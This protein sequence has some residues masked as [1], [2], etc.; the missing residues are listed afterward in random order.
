VPSA[1][2]AA[3]SP[4]DDALEPQATQ[5]TAIGAS[6]RLPRGASA[7]RLLAEEFPA[8]QVLSPAGGPE[9]RLRIEQV[10]A[11]DPNT[12]CAGQI[13]AGLE[14]L[15]LGGMQVKVLS[16]RAGTVSG[17]ESRSAWATVTGPGGSRIAGLLVVRT[18][19]GV[20]ASIAT[21]MPT[22][23]FAE[24][25]ALLERSLATL[26]VVD[27][28]AIQVER[29]AAIERGQAFLKSLSKERLRAL[30]DGTSR[31]RRLWRTDEDGEPEELGW[32]EVLLR[33]APRSSAGR[34]GP[35]VLDRPSEREEGLLISMIARTTA[36]DGTD[37]VETRAN[38]WI[39]WDLGSEAW[40]VRS[41]QK[42]SGPKSRFEQ[43]GMLP[44]A[45]GPQ[46]P[47]LMVATDVG[48]GMAEPA[49]WRRPPVAY[50]PQGLALV[51][52]SLLPQNETA[53]SN[54]VFYAL[55]PATGRLCQRLVRWSR[56][57][58]TQ[59]TWK[60]EVQNTPDTPASAEWFDPQGRLVK[61]QEADGS[62]M[63]PSTP[64]EIQR[65]WK[66]LGLDP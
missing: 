39:A 9:W 43:V 59:G 10:W 13:R 45:D 51:L 4:A 46:D 30:A 12:D 47:V 16:E 1:A 49:T 22:E 41:E 23:R 61:R 24:T 18:G 65:R 2:P 35:A 33:P 64:A 50:L 29:E 60:L 21:S 15:G 25:E 26:Q 11:P 20:F 31:V 19:D 52:G 36:A 62:R 55:D 38:Y 53:P 3:V 32:V 27:P 63:E 34:S 8:W 54:M 5:F 6:I 44:R 57:P 28:R 37:R 14:G 66:A 48:A 17:C 42:G 58:D 40:T 56:D 7:E